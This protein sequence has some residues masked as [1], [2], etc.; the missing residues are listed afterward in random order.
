MGILDLSAVLL[1]DLWG[2]VVTASPVGY[3]KMLSVVS[4]NTFHKFTLNTLF[5]YATTRFH[6]ELS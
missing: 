2:L 4:I 1:R 3:I 6:S 5:S